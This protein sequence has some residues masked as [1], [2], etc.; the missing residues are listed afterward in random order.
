MGEDT[1]LHPDLE[2][3]THSVSLGLA[4][5]IDELHWGGL[6]GTAGWEINLP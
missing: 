3:G 2:L 5:E 6:Q 4:R 1:A